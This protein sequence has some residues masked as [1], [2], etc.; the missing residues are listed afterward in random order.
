MFIKLKD[1][2]KKIKPYI[3][4]YAV[5]IAI[6]M[7]VGLISAALTKDSMAVYGELKSPPLSPPAVVFPIVW[8]LLFILMDISSAMIYIDKE[9]NPEAAKMGLAWYA[10]SLVLNFSWSIIFFNMQAAFFA[11]IVIVAL[12]YSI[13][14]T[15][16]EYR[17]VKPLAAFL[18]IP[19]AMWVIFAAYLNGGIWLLN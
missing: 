18:Q 8:F 11:L 16:F 15:I 17:K 10:V 2:F 3:L 7:M 14:R 4:P 6:P 9:K 5:A 12:A 19:Y 1:F 13:I